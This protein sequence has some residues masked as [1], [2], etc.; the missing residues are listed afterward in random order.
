MGQTGT[1]EHRQLLSANQGIQSVNGGNTR[2]NKLAG[3]VPS[4][5]IQRFAVDV[6]ALFGDDFRPAVPGTAHAV[7]HPAQHVHAYAQLNTPAQEAHGAVVNA[8]AVA[9]FEHLHQGLVA[10]HF[11]HLA[12]TLFAVGLGDLH[13][14]VIGDPGDAFHQHQGAHH[15]FD[16]MVFLQHQACPP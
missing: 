1:G 2:L 11:Q 14:L 15:L 7:K 8:Q 6:H 16:G 5:G 4:G 3:V 9:G 12:G 13:Q 10:V